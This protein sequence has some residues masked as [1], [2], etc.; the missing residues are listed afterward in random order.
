MKSIT[1]F[2]DE[3]IVPA[4]IDYIRIPAKSPHFDKAW[5][6]NGHIEAAVK[7]A[8]SWCEKHAVPGMK[9]EVV[10][11]PGRTPFFLGEIEGNEKT[12]VLI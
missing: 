9:L 4:L 3:F 8:A 1:H 2:W 12:P 7:L 10:R 11:L 5:A 6:Q